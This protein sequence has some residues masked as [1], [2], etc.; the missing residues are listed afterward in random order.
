MKSHNASNLGRTAFALSL[1][2]CALFG[3]SYTDKLKPQ[4][5]LLIS[6]QD[7]A[8]NFKTE[9]LELFSLG[10]SRLMSSLLW[11][12][13]LLEADIDHYKGE[14]NSWMYY[15]FLSIARLE[16]YFYSNYLFGGQYLS[17]IKDDLIGADTI[18]SA[19]LKIYPKD[20]WLSYH[21]G[22]NASFEMNNP[23]LGLTYYDNIYNTPEIFR[24]APALNPLISKLKFHVGA[25]TLEDTFQ[26]LSS[27]YKTTA[28][29]ILKDNI[30][31]SLYAI[32]AE[33]D[34]NCL[35]NG[36]P[37][38]SKED[39][40]NNSYLKNDDDW[41]SRRPWKPFRLKKRKAP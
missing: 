41:Y 31:D 36:L 28:P 7:S 27:M 5:K 39:F 1:A 29:G 18:Y 6:K 8:I 19:G 32:K 12:S 3:A 15:R 34:L 38:C 14:G 9:S 25:L 2:F 33:I 23:Q 16:P 24:I 21:A 37:N 13:T 26:A 22:F 11:V 40:Y 4:S 10:H 35:N 20:F 17:I 30:E